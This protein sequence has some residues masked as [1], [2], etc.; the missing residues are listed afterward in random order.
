MTPL[1]P[2]GTRRRQLRPPDRPAPLAAGA[3]GPARRA[4]SDPGDGLEQLFAAVTC[5]VLA[6]ETCTWPAAVGHAGAR[7]RALAA[8]VGPLLDRQAVRHCLFV[9]AAGAAELAVDGRR[10]VLHAGDVWLT[11]APAHVRLTAAH[12]P[13]PAYQPH[14]PRGTAGDAAGWHTAGEAIEGTVH[15]V[16]LVAQ[17]HGVL[18]LPVFF[19]L[20]GPFRPDAVRFPKIEEAVRRII[21]DLRQ[22]RPGYLLAVASQTARILA[23]LRRERV[24]RAVSP[25]RTAAHAAAVVRL[26]PV[27]RAIADR[28]AEPLTLDD[29]AGVV[30]LHP[31]HFARTF[32]AAVG[33]P[34][35]TYVSRYRLAQA[36]ALIQTTDL[37][38]RRVAEATGFYDA[39][40]LDRALRRAGSPQAR[41]LRS[42]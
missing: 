34:P 25:P 13:H 18:D 10:S 8:P 33:L 2:S 14:Q 5:S 31:T 22:R 1:Q 37:S 42:R 32:K 11:P 16:E 39:S 12:Q 26:L 15:V 17:I 21:Y 36:R 23:F 4:T 28:Y 20:V 6:A 24:E 40:H 35:L 29:L 38:L 3:L 27:L 7:A 19:D 30:H 41:A 9:C